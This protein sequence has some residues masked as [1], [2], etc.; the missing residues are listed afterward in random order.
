MKCV[1]KCFVVWLFLTLPWVCL[2]FVIVVSPNHTHLLT[3]FLS[4]ETLS[5]S[6]KFRRM[7]YMS[8]HVLLSIF[9]ELRKRD[10]IRGFLINK[11]NNTRARM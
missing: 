7:S 2:Q 6:L 9:N 4:Y 3:I 10:K 1:C 8:A 5:S 11:F